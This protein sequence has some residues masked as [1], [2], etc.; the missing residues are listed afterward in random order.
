M[1][2]LSS[3]VP[4]R[5]FTPGYNPF[6]DA[7]LPGDLAHL[8]DVIQSSG[9]GGSAPDTSQVRLEAGF[10]LGAPISTE[11]AGGT[12]SIAEGT[13]VH[14]ALSASEGIA[15][16]VTDTQ[17]SNIRVSFTGSGAEAR[18]ALMD[19]EITVMNVTGASVSFPSGNVNVSYTIITEGFEFIFRAF[20]S[21]AEYGE[22]GQIRFPQ[23]AR[24][25]RQ[26]AVR[27]VI[28]SQLRSHLQPMIRQMIL[29]NRHVIPGFDL[30]QV[31]LG[32]QPD[33]GDD[34]IEVD[35]IPVTPEE[36]EDLRQ[37]GIDLP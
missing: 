1:G 17:I 24:D 25:S 6:D 20:L 31:L 19:E 4:S 16:E 37:R 28:D 32:Q 33:S 27:A 30:S 21:L 11:F 23:D 7:D 26:P 36:A 35:I 2:L 12:L 15:D 3:N 29:D 13:G 22:A 5:M 34:L 9:G 14:I 8:V 10:T 18:L